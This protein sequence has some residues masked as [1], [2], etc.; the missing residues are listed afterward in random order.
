MEAFN[1]KR[2]VLHAQVFDGSH[3][4][5]Q[6]RIKFE[7][8]FNQWAIKK[9]RMHLVL[10]DKGINMVK[11]LTDASLPHFGC[12]AYTLQLVVHDG[13]LSQRAVIDILSSCRKIVGHFRHS[14]LAYSR[15][16]VIQQNL[17]LSQHRLVP[18]EPL[19]WNSSLYMLQRILQQKMS[20]APYATEHSIVQ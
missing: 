2:A 15:L 14:S 3:T 12:F 9:D 19:R 6:I 17:G 11:A 4:G 7:K 16:R 8:M 20:L 10:H 5:D 13:V 18:D 1:R